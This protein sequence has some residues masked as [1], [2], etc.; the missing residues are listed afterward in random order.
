MSAPKT[1][2]ETEKRRHSVVLRVIA[3]SVIFAAV[4]FFG[5]LLVTAERGETPD[6]AE[7]QVDGRTGEVI[8]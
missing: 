1:N 4:L 8:E 5:F 2:V 6:G 3:A 7:A